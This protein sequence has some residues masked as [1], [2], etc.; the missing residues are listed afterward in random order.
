MATS[1]FDPAQH[2]EPERSALSINSR[3]IALGMELGLDIGRRTFDPMVVELMLS[4]RGHMRVREGSKYGHFPT[5]LL[6]V[7]SDPRIHVIFG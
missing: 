1:A 5:Q 3:N 6:Y 4:I 2:Y 7:I